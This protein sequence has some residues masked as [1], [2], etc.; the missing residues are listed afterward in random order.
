MQ[1]HTH[2]QVSV[3]LSTTYKGKK[4]PAPVWVMRYRLPSGKDSKKVVGR[5][6]KKRGRP[7]H[8][9]LTEADALLESEAF[10]AEHSADA[11]DARR[12]FRAA[13]DAF[14]RYSKEEK[15]LRGST[16]YAYRQIGDRLAKRPWRGELT[17]ADRALDTFTGADLLVLRKELVKAKRSPYTLN[18]YRRVLRGTFGTSASSPALAWAWMAPN[19]ESEGKLQFYTPAQVRRLVAKAHTDLDAAV[20]VLATEA[21]PRLSEIRGLKVGNID[22]E[23]GMLRFE[24]GFTTHGGHAGNKGRRVRSV[25][26]TANVRTALWPFCQGKSAEMLV[27]EHDAK[28]GEPICGTGIYRRFV[29]AG[30]KAGLPKLRLHDLRHTFGTQAIRVFKV[31]EV[32]RMMGHRHL[33]TTERYLHYSPDPDAA[34]K[35]TA[36]WAAGGEGENV[37]PLR[38]S[39]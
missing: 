27:F 10:A 34:A 1:A 17:W 24:D 32:Q 13:L 8:G 4:R 6:W 36:L 33:T 38:L 39:A 31:H 25:P 35:L 9:F 12:R 15:G 16:L 19:V 21:G 26:M 14:L 29:S 22:F 37:V 20:Y 11:P 2:A 23:V 28:P 3:H 30:E 18:H 5:A 7:P